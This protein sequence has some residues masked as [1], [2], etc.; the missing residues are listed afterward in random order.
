MFVVTIHDSPDTPWLTFDLKDLL[1]CLESKIERL[2]WRCSGVE[3]T[4]P[5]AEGIQSADE[6]QQ[7][8]SAEELTTFAGGV[9]Q[10]LDGRFEGREAENEE[11]VLVLRAVESNHW[12]VIAKDKDVIRLLRS[13]FKDVRDAS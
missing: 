10:V 6:K 2:V 3:C 13:R 11:P 7:T 4:G 1:E 9:E 8:L 12:V 5:F